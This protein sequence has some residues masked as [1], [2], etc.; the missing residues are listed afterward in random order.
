[1]AFRQDRAHARTPPP[2]HDD[3]LCH[4]CEVR[5]AKKLSY[6]LDTLSTANKVRVLLALHRTIADQLEAFDAETHD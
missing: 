6:E 5:L 2:H 3:Q 4:G 1:M